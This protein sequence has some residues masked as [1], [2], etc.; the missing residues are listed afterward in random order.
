LCS[1]IKLFYPYIDYSG[2][3]HLLTIQFANAI[4]K[5]RDP[6]WRYSD[7]IKK[8]TFGK[9]PTVNCWC[10]S[11]GCVWM[12][13]FGENKRDGNSFSFSHHLTLTVG[14]I[15]RPVKCCSDS[16]WIPLGGSVRK[17]PSYHPLCRTFR[18]YSNI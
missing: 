6:Q 15:L 8:E 10:T 14:V 7:P 9:F 18:R 1:A 17:S 2:R 16:H 3:I 4:D 13:T 12:K 11:A 5:M